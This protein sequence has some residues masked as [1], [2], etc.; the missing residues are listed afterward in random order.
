MISW[1]PDESQRVLQ[2]NAEM[3]RRKRAIEEK[4]K[5]RLNELEEF[6]RI[7]ESG[8]LGFASKNFA[9]FKSSSGTGAT[10]AEKHPDTAPSVFDDPIPEPKW[11]F[12][13]PMQALKERLPKK[14]QSANAKSKMMARDL[15]RGI[16]DERFNQPLPTLGWEILPKDRGAARRKKEARG[17]T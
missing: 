12:T 5:R 3:E 15:V 6:R 9:N 4:T 14:G 10:V 11:A 1:E 7:E 2:L 13:Q 8:A 16:L 17:E